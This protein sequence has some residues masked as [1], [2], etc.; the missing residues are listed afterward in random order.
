MENGD[1]ER[2]GDERAHGT[3]LSSAAVGTG[4]P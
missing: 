4:V 2:E 1:R 3:S